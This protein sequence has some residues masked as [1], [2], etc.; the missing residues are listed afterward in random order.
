MNISINQ[1]Y[2]LHS[3]HYLKDDFLDLKGITVEIQSS[4]PPGLYEL[5]VDINMK[6]LAN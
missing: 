2:I 4:W 6:I 3:R 1:Y 5:L